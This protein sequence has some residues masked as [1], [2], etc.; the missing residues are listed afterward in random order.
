[1]VYI[2]NSWCSSDQD[3]ECCEKLQKLFSKYNNI[4]EAAM[5][6]LFL[7]F[8]EMSFMFYCLRHWIKLIKRRIK[9]IK[10]IK[11]KQ[12]EQPPNLLNLQFI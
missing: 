11:L 8:K 3:K 4:L 5:V 7:P 12:L 2:V 6:T 10:K 1:M 9:E